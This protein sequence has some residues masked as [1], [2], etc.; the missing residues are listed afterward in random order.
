MPEVRQIS[1]ALRDQAAEGSTG[2]A[3]V[4]ANHNRWSR[5]VFDIKDIAG[6]TWCEVGF[7][8]TWH[9]E[10]QARSVLDFASVGID[11][12]AEDGSNIDFAYVPG[13]SRTQIDP[14]SHYIAGPAFHDRS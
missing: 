4:V 10:E 1:S 3:H 7:Q 12:L 11:F 6:D 13:L 5:I 2:D 14:H 9:T 8:I